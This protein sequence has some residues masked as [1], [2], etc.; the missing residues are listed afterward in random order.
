MIRL[1]LMEAKT[2]LYWY[3]VLCNSNNTL[4]VADYQLYSKLTNAIRDEWDREKTEVKLE[5]MGDIGGDFS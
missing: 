2:L 3:G 4:R 1:S 5:N